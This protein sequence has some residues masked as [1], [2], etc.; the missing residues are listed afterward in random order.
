MATILAAPDLDLEAEI[1]AMKTKDIREELE[2]YGISTKSFFEKSELVNALARARR[3]EMIPVDAGPADEPVTSTADEPDR[4][5]RIRREVE[6]CLKMKVGELKKELA[7]YGR[8]IKSFFEKDDVARAVAEA[9]VDGPKA[10]PEGSSGSTATSG[11]SGAT[12]DIWD[13]SYRDVAV[14]KFVAEEDLELRL[15]GGIIDVI[16]R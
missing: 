7:S 13:P 4:K 1:R 14:T 11:G 10:S 3:E 8:S 6:K 16:A 5:E 15:G 2:S 9:R 12:E